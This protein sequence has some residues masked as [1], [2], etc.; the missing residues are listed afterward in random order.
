MFP[1][2]CLHFFCHLTQ[3]FKQIERHVKALS[4]GEMHEQPNM[5]LINYAKSALTCKVPLNCFEK[6]V[7]SIQE[8]VP[9]EILS[10]I[11]PMLRFEK[12]FV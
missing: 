2:S 10:T 3:T 5:I 4:S 8:I 6:P 7:I 12:G 11:T 9:R 1:S